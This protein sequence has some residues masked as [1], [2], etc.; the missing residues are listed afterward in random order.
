[1]EQDVKIEVLKT[2]AECGAAAAGKAVEILRNA[3]A[4]RGRA[5]FIAATGASQFEFLKGLTGQISVGLAHTRWQ[6]M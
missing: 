2:T 5:S 1:M 6:M 3:I 4:D